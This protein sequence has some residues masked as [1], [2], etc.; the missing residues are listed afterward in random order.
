MMRADRS[1]TIQ[2]GLPVRK[3]LVVLLATVVVAGCSN[4]KFRRTPTQAKDTPWFCQMDETRSD[5]ECVQDEVLAK[6]PK[7]ERLPNDPME[8]P[9]RPAPVTAA[10][11]ATGSAG[12]TPELTATAAPATAEGEELTV[13]AHASAGMDA[14]DA[15]VAE[16]R[17]DSVA[18]RLLAMSPERFAVQLIALDSA[19]LAERFIEENA[20]QDA[21]VVQ[22][23][24]QKDFYYVVIFG[25]Y[26]S[27]EEAQ[28]AFEANPGSLAGI[29][30]WIRSLGS[31]QAAIRQVNILLTGVDPQNHP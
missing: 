21:M 20:L 14:E 13:A 15:P 12:R 18:A 3:L 17:D 22:L 4:S 9:V 25:I 19:E 8:K 30:P 6:N 2:F 28:A 26:D 27:F 31:L 24:R 10:S 23:A 11:P 29:K 16:T 1:F 5:W 7:P